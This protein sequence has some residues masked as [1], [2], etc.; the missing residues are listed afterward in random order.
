MAPISASRPASAG[1][2][3]WRSRPPAG[4]TRGRSSCPRRSSPVPGSSPA[5]GPPAADRHAVRRVRREGADV[6]AGQ[7]RA[8]TGS[9]GVVGP[10]HRRRTVEARAIRSPR[11][12]PSMAPGPMQEPCPQSG[13]ASIIVPC[14]NQLEFTRHCLQ[15]LFRHTRPALGADRRRQRLDRRH[16]RLPGRR[17]GRRGRCRSRSSPM[18]RTG[19]SPRRSTR[20]CRPRAANTSCCSTTT[21]SS[22]TAGSISSSR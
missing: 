8:R 9:I 19:G 12:K 4:T 10:S 22:P 6:R 3:S 18:P 13:L 15:A 7:C 16:R 5:S 11:S 17:A 20:A 2:P 21:W 1:W 14:W